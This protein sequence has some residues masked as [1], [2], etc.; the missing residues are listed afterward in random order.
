MR[1]AILALFFCAGT[2]ALCQTS[3]RAPFNLGRHDQNPPVAKPSIDLDKLFSSAPMKPFIPLE[4]FAPPAKAAAPWSEDARIDPKMIVHPPQ[5]SFGLQQGIPVEQN[6][7]ANLR[8]LPIDSP[9]SGLQP[10]PNQWPNL[11]VQSIPTRWPR[12]TV[13]QVETGTQLTV[14]TPAR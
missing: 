11:K 5:A 10:I 9:A 8:M 2:A 7:Y 1:S 13:N 12:L 14:Q 4:I 3:T 6:E